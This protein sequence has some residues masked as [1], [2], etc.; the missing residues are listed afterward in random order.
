MKTLLGIREEY[1]YNIFFWLV[2]FLINIIKDKNV[3]F[4]ISDEDESFH[5]TNKYSILIL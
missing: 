5:K 3:D 1:K 2:F 4:I